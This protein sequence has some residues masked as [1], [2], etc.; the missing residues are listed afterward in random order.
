[1]CFDVGPWECF[2]EYVL[3]RLE[4]LLLLRQ[5]ADESDS[6][7]EDNDGRKQSYRINSLKHRSSK[8]LSNLSIFIFI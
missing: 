2:G 5:M 8:F 3:N 1:M 6:I 7:K 4:E